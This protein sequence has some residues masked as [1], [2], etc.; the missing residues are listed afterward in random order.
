MTKE[1]KCLETQFKNGKIAT[2]LLS[3]IGNIKDERFRD[4]GQI[5]LN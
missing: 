5:R 3:I 1:S 4:G 2:I